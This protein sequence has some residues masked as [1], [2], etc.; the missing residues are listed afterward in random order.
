M[1]ASPA[2]VTERVHYLDNVRALAML[3]G[4]VFHGG[5][6]YAAPSQAVWI[7]SDWEGSRA[8]DAGIWL[9]HTFRMATFFLIAGYFAKLLVERRGVKG[10][11]ANRFVRIVLPFILFYPVLL[12]GYVVAVVVAYSPALE[13]LPPIMAENKLRPAPQGLNTMHLW[14]LYYLAFF[15]IIA[16]V[17]SQFPVTS[18]RRIVDRVFSSGAAVIAAPLLLVPALWMAGTPI[19]AIESFIPSL[20]PFGFY[21]LYFFAGWRLFSRES[22]LDRLTPWLWPLL[23]VS[24]AL[25]AVHYYLSPDL[26]ELRRDPSLI[27]AASLWRQGVLAFLSAYLAAFLTLASLLLGKRYL[28]GHSR[29]LRFLSDASYWIYLVHLPLILLIQGMLAPSHMSIW[30]K[31]PLSV[32]LTFVLCLMFYASFVRY[33]PIGWMLHGKKPFPWRPAPAKNTAI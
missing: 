26:S 6:T 28:S 19:P 9:L 16:A 21:G 14:F 29:V 30:I 12:A 1:T 22:I 24:G 20:W 5:L 15:S 8:I 32:A 4:L 3:L 11:L 2:A 10:F 7:V 31:F 13:L 25:Y 23:F 18:F 17:A 33:T 27:G